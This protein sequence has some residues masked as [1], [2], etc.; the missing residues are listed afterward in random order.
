MSNDKVS[1]QL[2]QRIAN[3]GKEGEIIEVSH[4]YAFNYLIAKKL[5]R[6]ATP[7][8]ITREIENKRK[9]QDNRSHLVSARHE[10]AKKLHDTTLTFEL[11]GA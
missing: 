2:L 3:V 7:D 8:L 5:A 1:V 10:I 6:L 9:T 4:A 11:T